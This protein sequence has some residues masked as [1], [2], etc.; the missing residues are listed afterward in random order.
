MSHRNNVACWICWIVIAAVASG[1]QPSQ[2]SVPAAA[3]PSVQPDDPCAQRLHD[4]CGQMLLYHSIHKKLPETLEEL[5]ALDSASTPLVCPISGE[6]YI[7]DPNGM[8]IQGHPGWLVLYDAIASH[9]GMRWGIL[10]DDADRGE[11]LQARVILLPEEQVSWETNIPG[12]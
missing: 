4:I 1:C 7:Y 2:K 8:Q 9:S 12:P 3:R 11:P 10:V 6:P 5:E